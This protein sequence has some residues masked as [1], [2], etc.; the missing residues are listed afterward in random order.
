MAMYYC[1]INP[2][3]V[4]AY[5]KLDLRKRKTDRVDAWRIAEFLRFAQ[6]R[7]PD[8]TTPRT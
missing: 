3:Q 1:V 8:V 6:S 2:L 7:C 4:R 5:R